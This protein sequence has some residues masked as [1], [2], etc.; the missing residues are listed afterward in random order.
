M[1]VGLQGALISRDVVKR[2]LVCLINYNQ[3]WYE[4]NLIKDNEPLDTIKKKKE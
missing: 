1:K 4:V 2:L 3:G